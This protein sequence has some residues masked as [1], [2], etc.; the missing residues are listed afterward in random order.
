MKKA[1]LLISFCFAAT[2]M[3]AQNAIQSA[4]APKSVFANTSMAVVDAVKANEPVDAKAVDQIMATNTVERAASATYTAGKAI[5]LQPGFEARA[6]SVFVATVAPVAARSVEAG[7]DLT[8][9]AWPNPFQDQTTVEYKLPE[10]SKVKH[11]LTD[12]RGAILRQN[13]PI[14]VQSAGVYKISVEGTNL[15]T[16]VYLYQVQTGT[17]TKTIRLLKQ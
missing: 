17:Q 15:P 7:A 4:T 10:N 12:S 2:A 3:Q 13:A 6:G 5:I 9:S 14:D 8:V 16:G 11:T 1:L